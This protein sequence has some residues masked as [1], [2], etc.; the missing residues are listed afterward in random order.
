MRPTSKSDL[1]WSFSWLALQGFG[2]VLAV[3]QRVLV[4]KKQWLT[5]QEF[6]EDWA[7]AQVLPGP[8]VVNLS[9][10]LGDRHFGLPG[11]LAALAGILLFPTLIVLTMVVVL[12]G[13]ADLP[14]VQNAMRGVGAVTAGLIAATGLK[15]IPAL[16]GHPMGPVL[17][18][19][20]CLV[21]FVAVAILRLPLL[22][23][24][25]TVGVGSAVWTYK[26]LQAIEARKARAPEEPQA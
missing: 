18:T 20:F 19:L 4:E 8:N 16:R 2:G 23:V 9:L 21:T 12:S 13:V 25:L 6:I 10:M 3:V 22:W 17:C 11:A 14:Q 1:F 7:V 26:A 15:L 24:L 5:R